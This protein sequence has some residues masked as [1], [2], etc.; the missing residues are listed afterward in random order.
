MSQPVP[1]KTLVKILTTMV[2]TL[3][4]EYG[5]FWDDD[6]TMPWKE[7]YW[8]LQED[9]R[10]R[11][12][13]ESTLKE[14]ALLGHPLP[15]VLDGSRLR[16]IADAWPIAPYPEVEP[17]DRLFAGIRPRHLAVVRD[18]GLRALHRSYIPLWARRD[19]AERM[20]RRR[21]AQ[22]VVLEIR[23]REA[24]AAGVLFYRAGEDFFLTKAVDAAYVVLPLTALEEGPEKEV[25]VRPSH[26]HRASVPSK[27]EVRA[28]FGSFRVEAQ[29][30]QGL[31][32]HRGLQGPRPK[33]SS[34]EKSA[35]KGGWKEGA[36]KERRKRE[37]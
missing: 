11:F 5:L 23:A 27:D 10:L 13:R 3:P 22:P 29:H 37:V 32:A 16:R 34:G 24:Y 19:T 21:T 35:K 31:F 12:V 17:P 30:L 2:C 1:P 18:E 4:H 15:F 28:D 6:G 36:R 9:P 33:A 20:A 14:M 8:A 26:R 7:F 25:A